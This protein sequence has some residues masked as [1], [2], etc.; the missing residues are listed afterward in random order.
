MMLTAEEAIALAAPVGED[1]A[2]AA[3]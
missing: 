3:A 1:A 2:R